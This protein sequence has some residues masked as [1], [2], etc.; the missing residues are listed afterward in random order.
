MEVLLDTQFYQTQVLDESIPVDQNGATLFFHYGVFNKNTNKME[1]FSQ[2]QPAAMEQTIG[3]NKA[4]QELLSE[5]AEK[6]LEEDESNVV[7]FDA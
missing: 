7:Q 5:E 3:L 4:L 2:F 1:S 6:I